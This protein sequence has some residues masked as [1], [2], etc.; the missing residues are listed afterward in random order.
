MSNKVSS[1]IIDAI[2]AVVE[3]YVSNASF[4]KTIQAT[5]MACVD[6]TIGK[7][8]VKYQDS[9]F[10]AYSSNLD[11]VYTKGDNVY[12]LVPANDMGKDK[13]IVGTVKKLGEN[14]ISIIPEE[15]TYQINGKNCI[16]S[17]EEFKL[18]SYKNYGF[19]NNS[20]GEIILFDKNN[21]INKIN[22][23]EVELF[24]SMSISDYIFCGAQFKTFLSTEQQSNGD[25]GLEFVIKL[26]D[27]NNNEIQRSLSI[28]VDNMIG[29]PYLQTNYT[30]QSA[31]FA[32]EK[33]KF[34]S[35]EQIK[36][37]KKDF[38]TANEEKEYDLF[39]KNLILAGANHLSEQ[40]INSYYLT[41]SYPNGLYF[42]NKI[43]EDK[44]I[45]A[46]LKAKGQVVGDSSSRI[47]YFWFEQKSDVA[48]NSLREYYQYGGR[49]WCC[50]NSYKI[51]QPAEL[52]QSGNIINKEVIE[53]E[54][55]SNTFVIKKETVLTK[56]KKYKC[57]A[58]YDNVAISKEFVIFNQ[59]A[60]YDLSIFSENGNTFTNMEATTSL[61]C[62]INNIIEKNQYSFIYHWNELNNGFYTSI[63]HYL[64]EPN[65]CEVLL[66]NIVLMASYYCAVY[67]NNNY[68]G[69]AA[70]TLSKVQETEELTLLINNGT[71]VFLYD[72]NGNSPT[73]QDILN[74]LVIEPLSFTIYNNVTGEIF[75]SENIANEVIAQWYVPK[76]NTL[77]IP[78]GRD[79]D[80]DDKGNLI[81]TG[82]SFIYNIEDI[83][84]IRSQKNNIGLT[85]N[86]KG[87]ILTTKTN[88]TF[89]KQGEIGTNGTEVTCRILPILVPA[90]DKEIFYPTIYFNPN[91]TITSNFKQD[92]GNYQQWFKYEL[93]EN[94]QLINPALKSV[95]WSIVKDINSA[96]SNFIIGDEG[97]CTVN[98][99]S[100]DNKLINNIVKVELT[101]QNPE[102]TYYASLPIVT[103]DLKDANY[104]IEVEDYSGFQ[105]VI[106][107]NDGT[108]PKYDNT[109]P[110]KIHIYED[111]KEVTFDNFT[112]NWECI[113]GYHIRKNSD[114]VVVGEPDISE[115]RASAN[116][117]ININEFKIK[118]KDKIEGNQTAT[119]IKCQIFKNG[120]LIATVHIPIHLYLNRYSNS[121][122]NGWDG[123]SIQLKE[124]SSG[125]YIMVPQIGAGFKET[126]NSFTG[127]VMGKAYE[128]DTNTEK[129]GL[130]GYSHGENSFFLD[131]QTG[132]ASFGTAATGQIILNPN[133][134]DGLI[135]KSSN[136]STSNKT[137]LQINLSKPEIRYGS[138]NFIVNENGFLTASGAKING[139]FEVDLRDDNNKI[140]GQ[141]RLNEKNFAIKY[142]AN[143]G[144][145]IDFTQDH[146]TLRNYRYGS[147]LD[148]RNGRL[149]ITGDFYNYFG[150]PEG[151][152]GEVRFNSN[153][154]R[155]E[156]GD[157]QMDMKYAKDY[158]LLTHKTLHFLSKDDKGEKKSELKYFNGN[159]SI[160]G[161]INA[162]SGIIGGWVIGETDLNSVNSKILLDSVNNRIT[163]KNL[164][165]EERDL[166][167]DKQHYGSIVIESDKAD[168]KLQK[169]AIEFYGSERSKPI[170]KFYIRKKTS[171]APYRG[172]TIEDSV[173]LSARNNSPLVLCG[174]SNKFNEG[175][176]VAF[177]IAKTGDTSDERAHILLPILQ[178]IDSKDD[179]E[180]NGTQD[181]G[182]TNQYEHQVSD[183]STR[184]YNNHIFT[185]D[186]EFPTNFFKDITGENYKDKNDK[187]SHMSL[188]TIFKDLY[189]H[190][191]K[192]EYKTQ[193]LEETDESID[194]IVETWNLSSGKEERIYKIKVED[195]ESPDEKVTEIIFPDGTK[196]DVSKL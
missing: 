89:I 126:D 109:S 151:G 41:L 147:E 158:F 189:S 95:I 171:I 137:G 182:E 176:S 175:Q 87:K 192:I 132:N 136:Y 107:K 28:N 117:I 167:P 79:A 66:N 155:I 105:S 127:V 104:K 152:E 38:N 173:Y 64:N 191:T 25:F 52:D 121:A 131:A 90:R 181:E 146:F 170:G 138:N 93:R 168:I 81:Y 37:Y 62:K 111:N 48:P 178:T 76:D 162:T 139:T 130:L 125:G 71:Q 36:F 84:N 86:Y 47:R 98:T 103:V 180:E 101:T 160:T 102:K 31:Y 97:Y 7:Y 133:N 148:W 55:A 50:L 49:G 2:E 68:I 169:G 124:D 33:D 26:K 73:K 88:F 114:W 57:V 67:K 3:N 144:N 91:G 94:G 56:Q 154:I 129:I 5:V 12:I 118:P 24:Y 53:F 11:T 63:E 83:Y 43:F 159:L 134:Q 142:N 120:I 10:Y 19:S 40:E 163:L 195:R 115:A 96:Y 100:Q 32:I 108:S 17:S 185:R 39:V 75:E 54:P 110:F 15:E 186:I 22:L 18:C 177:I 61:Y 112:F 60:E 106:Y 23:D 174:S 70:L 30:S 74:P 161:E 44:K 143:N 14:Y 165:E 1:Q 141:I 150:D 92:I 6:A 179:E 145:I 149:N 27:D 135:I 20:Y 123:N 166:P 65:R 172:I 116:E 187:E 34:V 46:N 153:G 59:D 78:L 193:P 99:I 157:P 183:K 42:D 82:K 156:Y 69:T 188:K 4:D 113:G 58:V 164:T 16:S 184:I 13:T 194:Y 140:I 77:L 29:N 35:I 45:I 190:P 21:N 128:A 119:A 8:K 196:M 85:V 80:E 51:I 72:E 122:L 9:M